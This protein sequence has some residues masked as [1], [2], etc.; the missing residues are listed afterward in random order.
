M[1]EFSESYHLRAESQEAAITILTSAGLQGYVYPPK[2]GWITFVASE[3]SFVPDERIIKQNIGSLLHYVYA[4]DHGW[5]FA[6]FQGTQKL[7]SYSCEWDYT[8]RYDDSNCPEDAFR[9]LIADYG[10]G[11]ADAVWPHLHPKTLEDILAVKAAK[12]FARALGLEHYEQ[13]SFDYAY[14]DF[15]EADEDFEEVKEVL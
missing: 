4:G 11:S 9:Q 3:G 12:L 7:L 1:S 15:D 8:V 13:L 2:G 6:F 10:S 14:I 5:S